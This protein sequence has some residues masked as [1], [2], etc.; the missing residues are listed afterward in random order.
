MTDPRAGLGPL[1][2]LCHDCQ[3]TG[4][5][6]RHPPQLVETPDDPVV[7]KRAVLPKL[8]PTTDAGKCTRCGGLGMVLEDRS[9][10][11][12]AVVR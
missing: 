1:Y 9:T 3:G 6:V 8:N 11:R 10:P 7:T 4:G 5:E 12:L 2:Y